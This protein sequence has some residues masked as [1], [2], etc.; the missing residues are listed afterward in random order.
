ME[1]AFKHGTG[2]VENAQIDIEL[3]ASNGVLWFMVKNKYNNMLE[4]TKDKTSGIGLVNVK[5]RLN[6]LYGNHHTI[7]INKM[8]G[9]FTVSLKIN[10]H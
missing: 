10:L 2:M 1:N 5:R 6:L 8:D 4:E 7:N 3:S 9:W